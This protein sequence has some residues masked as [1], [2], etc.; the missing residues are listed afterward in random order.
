VPLGYD[1]NE[2]ALIIDPAEAESVRRISAPYRQ[3][4][5]VRRVKDGANPVRAAHIAPVGPQKEALT[6]TRTVLDVVVGEQQ[7]FPARRSR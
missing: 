5:C 4:G 3:L 2:R 1:A 7:L 6:G